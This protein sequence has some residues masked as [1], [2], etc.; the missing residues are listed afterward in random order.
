MKNKATQFVAKEF[1]APSSHKPVMKIVFTDIFD[2]MN[3]FLETKLYTVFIAAL[4][5]LY[6]P[7]VISPGIILNFF[8]FV[9]TNLINLIS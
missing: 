6:L 5:D 2:N 9:K 8:D 7:M 1:C 4:E 3:Y